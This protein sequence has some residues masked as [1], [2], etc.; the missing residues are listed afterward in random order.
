MYVQY[1]DMAYGLLKSKNIATQYVE[2]RT[3]FIISL[4]HMLLCKLPGDT[5]IKSFIYS[6]C[7]QRK[8]EHEL[9]VSCLK[10][11]YIRPQK[12]EKNPLNVCV[13]EILDIISYT[14]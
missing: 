2:M 13:H 5:L 11:N 1:G 8:H 7:I 14:E 4:I 10:N 6:L 9:T 12:K 3:C